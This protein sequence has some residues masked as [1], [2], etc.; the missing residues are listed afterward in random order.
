[1]QHHARVGAQFPIDLAGADIDG[2]DP[3]GS[4]LE[5]NVGESAGGGADIEADPAGDIDGEVGE[6]ASQFEAAA[7][8]V[9]RAREDLD[10][11]VV[12]DG[13]AGLG[14]FLAVEEHLA[15]H[16]E[17]LGFFAGFSEAACQDEPVETGFHN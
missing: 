3:R 17:G 8:D 4:G 5:Q 14:G 16:D 9:G 13:L 7:A 1:V 11:A 10:A 15:G 6:R 12:G 2:M